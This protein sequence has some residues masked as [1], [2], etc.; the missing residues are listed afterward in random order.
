MS[1]ERSQV[2]ARELVRWTAVAVLIVLGIVLYFHQART[3]QPVVQ[4]GGQ[5]SA[6]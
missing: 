4:A 1:E 3:V 6:P 5:E 2:T